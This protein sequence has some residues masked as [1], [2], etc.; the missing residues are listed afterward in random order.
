MIE[1]GAQVRQWAE[2]SGAGA[3]PNDGDLVDGLQPEYAVADCQ[4]TIRYQDIHGREFSSIV[5]MGRSGTK[6]ERHGPTLQAG[7]KEPDQET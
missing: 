3:V 5:R 1:P 4:L 2:F 6:L 7:A